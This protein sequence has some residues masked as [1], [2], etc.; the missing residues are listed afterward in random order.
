MDISII[1]ELWAADWTF[2]HDGSAPKITPKD[3]P[4]EGV[5]F[6]V[7]EGL[8]RSKIRVSSVFIKTIKG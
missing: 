1:E 3:V 6:V 2:K 4:I 7:L 5:P 8:Y